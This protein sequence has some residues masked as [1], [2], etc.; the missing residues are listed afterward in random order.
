MR[1]RYNAHGCDELISQR[2]CLACIMCRKQTWHDVADRQTDRQAGKQATKHA[3]RQA[4]RATH[5]SHRDE[6]RHQGPHHSLL[7]RNVLGQPYKLLGGAKAD[8]LVGVSNTPAAPNMADNIS[9]AKTSQ[10]RQV[11]PR[12]VK[13]SRDQSSQDMTKTK[14]RQNTGS[15]SPGLLPQI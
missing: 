15:R 12:P 9:Q 2:T 10:A 6:V 1:D 8:P 7:A 3:G 13:T 11:K 5:H 4:R 14:P